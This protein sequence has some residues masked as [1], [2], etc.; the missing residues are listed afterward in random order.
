MPLHRMCMLLWV[1]SLGSPWAAAPVSTAGQFREALARAR[2][3]DTIAVAPGVYVDRRSRWQRAFN[4]AHSGAARRPIVIR[5]AKLHAATLRSRAAHTPALGIQF[6][7]HIIVEGFRI[8]GAVGVKEGADSCII[9]YCDVRGG[10]I[11]GGDESLHWG[12][13]VSGNTQG[14]RIEH[15][16]IHDMAPIGNRSHNGACV[17][18][19]GA[20]NNIIRH[21][22][23]DG[24]HY[25]FAAFGQKGGDTHDNLYE[26]NTARRCQT[27]FFGI[28]ST[29]RT[30]FS[31]RNRYRFNLAV[32]CS[33][34]LSVSH[35]CKDFIVVSNT[36]WRVNTFFYGGY[37]A[38]QHHNS[39]FR[40]FR[41]IAYA[42]MYRQ[43]HSRP[44]SWRYLIEQS[45]GNVIPGA[46]ALWHEGRQRMNLTMWRAATGLDSC[47]SASKPAFADPLDDNFSL[48]DRAAFLD[49]F[50]CEP[51][52][53]LR[54]VGA[55]CGDRLPGYTW[56]LR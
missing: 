39:G 15:N 54:D 46:A 3:G 50:P 38:R 40:F 51:D 48:T 32:S 18:I 43:N 10:F 20:R 27:G 12:V 7:S 25:M 44:G 33:S 16:Y 35:N 47:S 22:E 41:N 9:R 8:E 24:S 14:C 2:P 56:P 42:A 21:N 55:F 6:R 52:S 37:H 13:Y 31:A 11:Q 45:D 49:T 5:S 4:P 28:G 29:D 17:M 23:A 19:H 34:F 30:R 1:L 36:A 53:F 26:Y